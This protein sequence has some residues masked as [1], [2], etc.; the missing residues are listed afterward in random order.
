VYSN[1]TVLH[2]VDPRY[3]THVETR[4][5]CPQALYGVTVHGPKDISLQGCDVK[6]QILFLYPEELTWYMH[7]LQQEKQDL[8]E[9]RLR[10]FC[11][12]MEAVNCS[13]GGIYQKLTA[14]QGDAYLTYTED[15]L[16]LFAEGVHFHVRCASA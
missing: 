13:L 10:K 9:Q 6:C 12:V 4:F 3:L 5:S 11:S 7:R 16:L 2:V 15:T 1:V 8:E 14:G